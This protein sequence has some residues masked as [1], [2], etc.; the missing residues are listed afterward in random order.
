[1]VSGIAVLCTLGTWQ[2]KRLYWKEALIE[3]VNE[4]IA[5]EP[6]SLFELLENTPSLD[7]L[8]Y[9]PAKISGE[10]DH[11][12]EVYY[13]TTGKE[14]T[15]GWNVHTP[16]IL[17]DGRILIVNRGFVPDWN[18]NPDTRKDGQITGLQEVTGLVRNPIAQKPNDFVPDNN[19]EK[20]EFFWR[21][22][23]QMMQ[24]MSDN[25]SQE[26]LPVILDANEQNNPAGWPQGGTTIIS[27]PN[28][29]LQYAFTWFGL[30][31]ALLMV[32]S[33]FIYSRRTLV[34]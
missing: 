11:T 13:F 2:M 27:F 20:R 25:N 33:F 32:G 9:I 29:H 22:H 10:Y 3:K 18:K 23:K 16:L 30:A 21:S 34:R 14:S 6:Q 28:N 5:S 4:R 1:M 19:L 26:F 17:S 15:S 8:N 31:A 7:D 12:K 24:L